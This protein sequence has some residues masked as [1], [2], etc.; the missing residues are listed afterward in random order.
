M[1]QLTLLLTILI[2]LNMGCIKRNTISR[3]G[4]A[5]EMDSSYTNNRNAIVVHAKDTLRITESMKNFEDYPNITQAD[6]DAGNKTRNP[7]MQ[8][9]KAGDTLRIMESSPGKN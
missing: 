8:Y 4:T 1:K 9:V 2:I 6:I 3:E 7:E 5:M